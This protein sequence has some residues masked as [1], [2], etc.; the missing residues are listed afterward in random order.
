MAETNFGVTTALLKTVWSKQVLTHFIDESFWISNGFVGKGINDAGSVIHLVDELSVSERGLQAVIPLRQPVDPDT[1]TVNDNMLT[2]RE[3]TLEATTNTIRYD[4][5]RY[6]AKNRGRMAEQST[7]LR[8]RVEAKGALGDAN[9][10]LLDELAF[11]TAAGIS[12]SKRFDGSSRS[13][14]S[15]IPQLSFNQDIVAPSSAR[16]KVAGGYTTKA[17]LTAS[18][19]MTW[20]IIRDTKA[21]AMRER[22]RPV[23]AGGGKGM[24]VCVMTPEQSRDLRADPEYINAQSNA[25]TRGPDNPLFKGGFKMIDG[26]LLYEHNKVP[27]TLNATS[28]NKYGASGT[29]DGAQALFLGAQSLGWAKLED[30]SWFET[31]EDHGNKNVISTW[32]QMGLLKPQ[33][34]RT[35]QNSGTAQDFGLISIYTGAAA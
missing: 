14:M 29:V 10:E 13:A 23:G 31:T 3:V 12:Y 2:N 24:Y 17:G 32:Q 34:A 15:Q 6:G 35:G 4:Q 8:F 9:A 1:A 5:I 22:V 30:M 18:D 21:K 33:F 19:K 25:N 20:S 26:V 28:G 7:V 16:I 11:L 27:N